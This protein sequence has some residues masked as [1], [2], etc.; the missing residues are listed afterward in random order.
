MMNY[1]LSKYP[2]AYS[3]IEHKV[4][5]ATVFQTPI[6]DYTIRIARKPA[7]NI[8]GYIFENPADATLPIWRP[9]DVL[10]GEP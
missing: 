10:V 9:V 8:V 6:L 7:T 5:P 4:D 2:V 1:V 3:H